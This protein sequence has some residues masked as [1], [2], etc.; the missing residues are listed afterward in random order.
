MRIQ[1]R[2]LVAIALAVSVLALA[3][4]GCSF[5]L[6]LRL[7]PSAS[8]ADAPSSV[9]E[10]RR[11][12]GM[13]RLPPDGFSGLARS[14]HDRAMQTRHALE[15]ACTSPWRN[16]HRGRHHFE[17]PT[18]RRQVLRRDAGSRRTRPGVRG[19]S[20]PGCLSAATVP[21]PDARQRHAG[22]DHGLGRAPARQG[23]PALVR[24]ARRARTSSPATRCTGRAAR[25][26]GASCAPNAIRPTS[27]RLSM[28]SPRTYG[29]TWSE[30]QS[31]LRKLPWPGHRGTWSGRHGRRQPACRMRRWAWRNFCEIARIAHWTISAQSG[32]AVRSPPALPDRAEVELC[33]RCH[34]HRSQISTPTCTASRCSIPHVPS[35]LNR[36]VL[37]RRPDEGRGLQLRVVP[38]EPDVPEGRDLQRLPQPA[39]A[40]APSTGQW[41]VLSV[42]CTDEVP[43]H[44]PIPFTS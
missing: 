39:F 24:P 15:R 37:A 21:G 29:S 27:R 31:R 19:H 33:A 36:P 18:A 16:L 6:Q 12:P 43:M 14:H 7:T 28:R 2:K 3:S 17:L 23:R 11:V 4:H 10:Y 30:G 32:S 25:T 22:T 20:H 8:G 35:L 38:A 41:G 5:G 40:Q 42:P 26:T 13:C 34:S 9:A 44:R 1:Q